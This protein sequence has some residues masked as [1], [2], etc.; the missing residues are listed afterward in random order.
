MGETWSCW[1][2]D[3]EEIKHVHAELYPEAKPLTEDKMELVARRFKDAVAA[4]LE[5]WEGTL[6]DCIR[7]EV[8]HPRVPLKE[9]VF[10]TQ[11]PDIF[12]YL[13]S[14]VFDEEDVAHIYAD[15]AALERITETY[16]DWRETCSHGDAMYE[17]IKE[18]V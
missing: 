6:G 8:K 9:R 12:S 18:E 7:L 13:D 15:E 17:A 3:S 14:G 2:L 4:L 1:T 11:Y 16:N 10:R 5:D